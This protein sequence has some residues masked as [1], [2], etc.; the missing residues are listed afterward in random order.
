MDSETSPFRVTKAHPTA[1]LVSPHV[2]CFMSAPTPTLM[3]LYTQTPDVVLFAMDASRHPPN[4]ENSWT[5][6]SDQ[7][8]YSLLQNALRAEA[9]KFEATLFALGDRTLTTWEA[10]TIKV[11]RLLRVGASRPR[12]ARNRVPC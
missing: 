5:I 11:R 8:V 2:P 12:V 3:G 7:M 4:E 10:G 9:T 1:P 6:S